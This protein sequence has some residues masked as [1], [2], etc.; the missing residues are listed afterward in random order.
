LKGLFVVG[1]FLPTDDILSDLGNAFILA[2]PLRTAKFASVEVAKLRF[3]AIA[4][5]AGVTGT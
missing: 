2:A 1:Y 4:T 5:Q 3:H